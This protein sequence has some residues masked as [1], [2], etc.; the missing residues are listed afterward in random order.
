M[1]G[2]ALHTKMK[3]INCKQW[4]WMSAY[5]ILGRGIVMS[6]AEVESDQGWEAL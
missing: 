5:Y 1:E 3:A 4:E 2:E 6:F